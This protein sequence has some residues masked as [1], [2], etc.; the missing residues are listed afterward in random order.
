[1]N[2]PSIS[3]DA[4]DRPSIGTARLTIILG[5][6]T[7]FGPLGI[8][9]YLSAF[10]VIAASLGASIADVQLSLSAF[11]LGL[12]IGQFVYGPAIDRFGRKRPLLLGVALFGVVSFAL[13]FVSDPTVFIA[14]RFVQALGAAAGMVVSRAVIRDLFDVREG[15]RVLSM[16]MA[17]VS[18]GPIVAPTLGGLILS[19]AHW[20]ALFGFIGVF[21]ALCFLAT[22]RSLPE[23]LAPAARRRVGPWQVIAIFARLLA[24]ARFIVPALA[25]AVAFSSVFAYVSGSP[26][27]F[28]GLYG[29]DQTRFGW[30]FG[31]NALGLVV[32]S[33]LNRKLLEHFA[34]RTI[35][36]NAVA[37]NILA[38]ALLVFVTGTPVLPVFM[39]PLML[40]MATVPLIGANATALAM[41]Q[42]GRDAGSA[43]SI[44]GVLQFGLGALMSALVGLLHDPSAYSMTM[45]MLAGGCAS[46][47]V[48]LLGRRHLRQVGN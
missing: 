44:I 7:I 33:Q 29:I 47:L 34:P 35:L 42:S 36:I 40:F 2:H 1:M 26:H 8:D 14:L 48:L 12:A 32:A 4:L 46:A 10:P 38:G 9:L 25:G 5:S 31:I 22:L 41:G 3:V 18:I 28:M 19:I 24:Q 39:A 45:P 17:I 11:V 15:A 37:V 6:L 27:V 30:V 13:M 43:S 20:H 21:A 16:M 23:T